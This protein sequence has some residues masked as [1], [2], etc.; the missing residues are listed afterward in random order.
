MRLIRRTKHAELIDAAL[1]TALWGAFFKLPLDPAG[2]TYY[3]A[4]G[5]TADR[6]FALEHDGA[7]V[8]VVECGAMAD[9]LSHFGFPLEPRVEPA[10]AYPL[11]QKAAVEILS[12]FRRLLREDS[13][14]SVVVRLTPA[15]D[16]DGLLLGPLSAEAESGR[17]ELRAESDLALDE[18][19]LFGDLRK[20]HRQQVRWGEKNLVLSGVDAKQPDRAA[21]ESYRAFHA[22]VAGRV[23]RGEES[24]NAMYDAIASGR[25]DLV[26]GHLDGA[27]VSGTLVLDGLDT[28]YYASGVYD[29][30][31]F[32]KPLGHAPLFRA[33]LRARN[34]GLKRFDIGE[35]P[36]EASAKERQI[37]YFKRGF[38]N[39]TVSSR[40][41]RLGIAP[42]QANAPDG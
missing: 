19:S 28:A 26:L 30:E 6:T 15:L 35:L 38:T 33:M 31:Q 34:R 7:I 8:C 41:F 1:D 29:R 25:G 2:R 40:I 20:G 11:R 18:E 27:L 16:P 24:W 22:K 21:F 3:R 39:R 5:G 10:L 14:A 42:P 36:S 12:E 23:T 4:V 13:L 32:D 37:G 9:E 17:I